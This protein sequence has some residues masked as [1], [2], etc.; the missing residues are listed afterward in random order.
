MNT[1]PKILIWKQEI[2]MYKSRIGINLGTQLEVCSGTKGSTKR[3]TQVG[4]H[5]LLDATVCICCCKCV[6]LVV[7]LLLL[8]FV[9]K[10]FFCCPCLAFV[11]S[12]VCLH[13][14]V[15]CV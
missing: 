6:F 9:G 10:F 4:G 8:F 7:S 1:W 15:V 12:S 5:L 2:H 14:I 11:V 13:K 3:G